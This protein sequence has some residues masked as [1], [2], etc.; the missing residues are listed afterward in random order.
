MVSYW[1]KTLSR[2]RVLRLS[3]ATLGGATTLSLIGCG[4]GK[5]EA[6]PAASG[7]VAPPVETT[8]KATRSGLFEMYVDAEPPN[9]DAATATSVYVFTA[10]A[11]AYPNLVRNK[12]VKYPKFYD[13][14]VEADPATSWEVP[15]DGLQYVFKMR[16]NKLDPRPPTNNRPLDANDVKWSW[17]AFAQKSVAR[18]GGPQTRRLRPS[19]PIGL[20]FRRQLWSL[21]WRR[22]RPASL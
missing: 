14:D 16:P 9:F 19:V 21:A 22:Q 1:S 11:F 20:A 17:E 8:A 10:A 4:G 13:G 2:R 15:P 18:T 5:D 6:K 3:A 12:M 7:L